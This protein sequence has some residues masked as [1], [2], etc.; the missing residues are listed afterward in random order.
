MKTKLKLVFTSLFLITAFSCNNDM[1]TPPEEKPDQ[2]GRRD[3]V[4]TIDTLNYPYNTLTRMWGS[5][6]TDVWAINSGD[7][8]KSIFHFDGEQWSTDRIFRRILPHSIWGFSSNNIWIGGLDGR[9]WKYNG[10]SWSENAV[11]TKDGND[12]VVF[13]NMWG[14]S[15]NS[16]YAFGAYPDDRQLANNSVIAHFTNNKWIM[17]D[18]DNLKGIVEHLY[19][20]K[21]N[22]KIY[23][24]VI[25]IGGGE[26]VDSTL[27][28][29][30][31]QERY[32]KLYGSI[33]TKGLQADI[34]LI[35]GEV[36]F[37]LG[38]EI[39]KRVDNKFETFLT[40]DN[41]DFYQ[42]IWGRNSKDIFLFMT[43]GLVH[44]NGSDMQYLFYFDKTR[45][46]IFGAS[47]FNK[48]VFFLVYESS[49]NL[50]LIYHGKLL[51]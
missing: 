38:N 25:K 49:T 41:E 28:Y 42:R 39:A 40:V 4:W 33:E 36:Y 45:T 19:K 7:F 2:P 9:I 3:Y 13:D 43:D 14:D 6:P 47:I 27:I 51:E 23:L 10:S 35:N 31:T 44:Y 18:T 29:E 21:T 37:V 17:L 15:P 8:Y 34:S 1:V 26:H 11:L 5:S 30:Y 50:N 48:E 20:N 16:L 32:N 12:D 22:N 46:Q 24:Q